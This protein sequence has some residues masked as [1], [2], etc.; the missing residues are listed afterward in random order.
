MKRILLLTTISLLHITLFGQ[1]L[2]CSNDTVVCSSDSV[3]LSASISGLGTIN[4]DGLNTVSLGDDQYSPAINVGFNF[5]FYGNTYSNCLISSN[6]Y[7]TFD[8]INSGGYSGW[9]IGGGVPGTGTAN[10][11][12]SPWQDIHPGLGGTI[13]Y[14]TFGTAPN[15][16]FVVRWYQIPMFS[17]T[18]SLFCSALFLHETT[19]II[20]THIEY[21]ALCATWN[22]G[23][24]IHALNDA[25]GTISHV[26]QDPV[27][28]ADRNFPLQWSTINDAWQFTPDPT[29]VNNYTVT[30]LPYSQILSQNGIVWVDQNGNQVGTGP[31]ITVGPT[32]TTT[33]TATAVECFSQTSLS[34]DVTVT[35]SDLT[36]S[37]TTT[38]I[39]C[40]GDANGTMTVTPVGINPP[41]DFVWQDPASTTI[42]TNL[43][44][45]GVTT[46]NGLNGGLHTAIVTDG[47]GCQTS[48]SA[49]INE[50]PLLTVN[51][52]G[53]DLSC[54]AIPDGS[55]TS[56]IAGGTSSGGSYTTSW[57]G[58]NGYTSSSSNISN[59]SPGTYTIT[60]TDDNGCTAT[61]NVTINQPADMLVSVDDI[62]PVT[63]F[64]YQDGGIS[65]ST[66]GG[67][68]PFT[69]NWSGPNGY[70]S[71]NEDIT[72]LFQGNYTVSVM[73]NQ[74]CQ[75][76]INAAVNQ[77]GVLSTSF[78]T[79]NY[80]NYDVSC[81]GYTDG[82][83][84][85]T[86][87]GGTS[88]YTYMW[89]TP[90]NDTLRTEDITDLQA[91]PY[92][93]FVTDLQNCTYTDTV[94]LTEPKPL[95]TILESHSDISCHYESDGFIETSTWGSV[96][97]DSNYHFKWE[98]PNFFYSYQP[99]IYNLSEPGLYTLTTTDD[100]DC[101]VIVEYDL[102]KPPVLEAIIYNLDD[103]LSYHYPYAN[104]YDYSR[105]NPTT[106]VWS[107]SEGIPDTYAK[108]HLNHF[109]PEMG[110]YIVSLLV[111][112]ATGCKDS[113]S[114]LIRVI[115]EHTL[116][117]PNAFTPDLDGKNDR[118]RVQHHALREDTYRIDIYDRLGS[119]VHTSNDANGE[120]DG[121]N[122]FTGNKLITGVY[123]YYISYQDWDGWKYDHTNCENCT[124]TVT[125]IR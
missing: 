114:K 87:V 4:L 104:F 53:T 78:I 115:D 103:T 31:V 6:N 86:T 109:Y 93:M 56:V 43:G 40:N 113:T 3:V 64:G 92:I 124:G 57:T 91:G 49:T 34:D 15:R 125:L 33:Y 100:N 60:V 38:D 68:A 47:V 35:V 39:L 9:I 66:T 95:I 41:Y 30:A 77:A 117:V 21:K 58:P 81:H 13:E 32:T 108:D 90:S 10:S 74:N 70:S 8:T 122:D 118:F 101:F 98:G 97:L 83:I 112:N 42:Q 80:N 24:A 121:T 75:K 63:C 19:N 59:L 110:E 20:E 28:L 1:S 96:A 45:T 54:F 14:G 123:T 12:M 22:N 105:G 65:I 76:I 16:I 107:F 52:V 7:I 94:L 73:D 2:T 23:Y 99:D 50:P 88:P 17:C 62:T 46:A 37:E 79:T 61:N 106:W 25:T 72:N 89:I 85:A 71:T 102:Q 82:V 55:I 119:L 5:D 27:L 69:Y 18:D 67:T 84:E 11:I 26:V 36:L 48:I 116:Y 51:N 44:A 111:E 120:W 29:N